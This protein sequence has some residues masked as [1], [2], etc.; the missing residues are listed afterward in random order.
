MF[1]SNEE[2]QENLASLFEDVESETVLF[3]EEF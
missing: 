3:S 2:F 1:C